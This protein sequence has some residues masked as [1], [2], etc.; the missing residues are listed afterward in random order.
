VPRFGLPHTVQ[1]GGR[2]QNLRI[3]SRASNWDFDKKKKEYFVS[4]KDGTSPFPLTQGVLQASQWTPEHLTVR[5]EALLEKLRQVWQLSGPAPTA[6][7]A[8]DCVVRPLH[9]GN[10]VRTE[11][12]SR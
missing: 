3:N 12:E 7:Q 8:P 2:D 11:A 9:R 6:P 5:Q 1:S 4:K 10:D